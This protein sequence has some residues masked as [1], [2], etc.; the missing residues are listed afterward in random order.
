[1]NTVLNDRKRRLQLR[2]FLSRKDAS[3]S[4]QEVAMNRLKGLPGLMGS[5]EVQKIKKWQTGKLE[6][7]EEEMKKVS[8]KKREKES[9][10][11]S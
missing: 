8:G 5:W 3:F 1:M 2:N 11:S 10:N 6:R 9:N 7:R 4:L